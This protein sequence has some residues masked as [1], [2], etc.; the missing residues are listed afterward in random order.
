VFKDKRYI[1][2]ILCICQ[3]SIRVIKKKQFA[4]VFVSLVAVS[5][6]RKKAGKANK[7]EGLV[8]I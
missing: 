6:H 2:G 3:K 8:A 1:G 4:A 5:Y 7:K